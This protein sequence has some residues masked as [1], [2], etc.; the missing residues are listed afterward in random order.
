MKIFLTGAN[1]FVGLRIA[2]LVHSNPKM[3]LTAAVRTQVDVPCKQIIQIGN[4]DTHINWLALLKDQDVVIHTAARVHIPEHNPLASLDAYRRINVNGTLTLAKQAAEA[5]VKRF[6]FISS[7]K[8][9]GEKTNPGY[10]FKSDDTPNPEVAYSISKWEAEQGLEQL[11]SITNMQVVIIRPPLIYGPQM[12]GNF[13]WLSS[14]I[15]KRVPLP[16]GLIKNKRSFACLDNL[17]D[18][19]ITCTRHPDAANQTFL[20]SDDHDLST[21]ELVEE[22]KIAMGKE[23]ILIPVPSEILNFCATLC[24]RSELSQ[25]LL[26]NL[27]IDMTKTKT[28]LG[29]RPPLSLKEGFYQCYRT[30]RTS[31]DRE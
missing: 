21:T 23:G 5:G 13:A 11:A 31:E 14:L 3:Y 12:K 4:L 26:G 15:K 24:G 29:W 18:L 16:L 7:I 1:G 17:V 2:Q 9:N 20:V 22:I 30:Y 10:P 8:V 6:I 25:R 28:M 27:Q 19:V